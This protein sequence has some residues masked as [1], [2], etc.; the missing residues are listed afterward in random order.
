MWL[1]AGCTAAKTFA[2]P[3]LHEKGV[4]ADGTHKTPSKQGKHENLK[5]NRCDM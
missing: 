1:K 3:K 2:A 4:A 5:T